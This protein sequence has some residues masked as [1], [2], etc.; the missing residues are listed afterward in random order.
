MSLLRVSGKAQAASATRNQHVD[1]LRDPVTVTSTFFRTVTQV[2][3][4]RAT[5]S[6]AE[7]EVSTVI[8][9]TE[10][11]ISTAATQTN[12]VWVTET[13][14]VKRAATGLA[15]SGLG[16]G[17]NLPLTPY[18]A[19][20]RV[21]GRTSVLDGDPAP[22][23]IQAR[24][25]AASTVTDRVT[26]IIYLTS[27]SSI[28]VT[29]YTTSTEVTTIYQ[30]QTRVLKAEATTT[31]T[32]TIT[33]TSH[34]PEVI[35]FTTTASPVPASTTTQ[36]GSSTASA[37]AQPH[38]LPTPTIAGIAVGS[39]VL[40]LLL[41]GFIILSIRRRWRG[42]IEPRQSAELDE[43][44]RRF[45]EDEMIPPKSQRSRSSSGTATGPGVWTSLRHQQP[46]LPHML[47]DFATAVA[48]A[49]AHHDAEYKLPA[50]VS[51]ATSSYGGEKSGNH[52]EVI[53]PYHQQQQQQQQQQKQ[54]FGGQDDA[55]GSGGDRGHHQRSPLGYTTLV[56]TPSPTSPAALALLEQQ[57]QQPQQQWQQ[58][59][60]LQYP[61]QSQRQVFRGP[62]LGSHGRRMHWV[63]MEADA[64]SDTRRRSMG[65]VR[66][67]DR[68]QG[69]VVRFTS[70]GGDPAS[71]RQ[72][73]YSSPPTAAG[74]PV[75][76]SSQTR[77]WRQYRGRTTTVGEL[78]GNR[79]AVELDGTNS[80]ENRV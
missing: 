57:P 12:V 68:V 18:H 62:S 30:T 72:R 17:D 38:P 42:R 6:V 10:V 36:A 44:Y 54:Q 2:A 19:R 34:P 39:S 55:D 20:A 64:E 1:K 37:S 11:T 24:Q 14:V 33:L 74:P 50:A 26:E 27:I 77:M 60:Y 75:V 46:T 76:G 9:S 22:I 41:A 73:A 59:Q 7:L 21:T 28:L 66:A 45:D 15:L 80:M 63:E 40:A 52:L 65:A 70:E 32:S 48:A 3:T 78:E 4:Q 61:Q 47:P 71:G 5:I 8:S 67:G 49:A 25:R 35:T 29:V 53:E 43:R 23:S 56:G 79:L 69:V 51:S 58:S 13:A 31:V 16:K